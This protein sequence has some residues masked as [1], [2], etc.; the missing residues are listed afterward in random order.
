M[1]P[2]EVA[3]LLGMDTD[4]DME[5]AESDEM[6]A[7][8]P[9]AVVEALLPSPVEKGAGERDKATGTRATG[10]RKEKD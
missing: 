2:P 5:A 3:R 9:E 8:L 7:G 4:L 6:E 10:K 1:P